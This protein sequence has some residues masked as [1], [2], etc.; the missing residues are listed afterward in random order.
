VALAQRM[1]GMLRNLPAAQD[2]GSEIQA[3]CRQVRQTQKGFT[4]PANDQQQ[5]GSQA[6]EDLAV[7]V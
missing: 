3:H 7:V 2:I 1:P 6:G 5:A 4:R